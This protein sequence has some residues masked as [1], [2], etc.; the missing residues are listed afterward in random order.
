MSVTS[1]RPRRLLRLCSDSQWPIGAT[2][3]SWLSCQATSGI[4]AVRKS[5]KESGVPANSES[6]KAV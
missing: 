4:S 3:K 1:A 2:R 6:G 5:G